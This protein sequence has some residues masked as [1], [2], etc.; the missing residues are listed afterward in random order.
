[1]DLSKYSSIIW[2]WNGTL[3]DDVKL[4]SGIM[5]NLLESRSLPAITINRYKEIFTFP[6]KDYYI[7]AGHNFAEESFEKIGADFM[8]EY[9]NK[10]YNC[11][12]FPFS[13]K[14]LQKI[15]SF[16]IRQYLLSAYRHEDLIE[17]VKHYGITEY[18]SFIKGLDHIYADD[19]IEI[20]KE[21][22]NEISTDGAHSDV[23]MIGDTIHD[24]EVAEELEADC[25]LIANGHQNKERLKKLSIPVLENLE[26]LYNLLTKKGNH[27]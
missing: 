8:D 27:S 4:C 13:T 18:F 15:Q 16:N 1:M 12:L 7:E 6:V 2:D 22:M 26:E 24:F 9:E 19:K 25:L 3:L 14:I 5:N 11:K 10:K 17:L 23:I 20:G 21:L